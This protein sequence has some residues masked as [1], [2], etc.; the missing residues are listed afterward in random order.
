[1]KG[2]RARIGVA[3]LAVLA[4]GGVSA[5]AQDEHDRVVLDVVSRLR[6]EGRFLEALDASEDVGDPAAAEEARLLVTWE[7]G[8]LGGALHHGLV[9]LEAQPDH[10]SLL[11]H[12]TR[13]ALDLAAAELAPR[14]HARL[15]RAV[16]GATG[17]DPSTREAWTLEI[18]RLAGPVAELATSAEARSAALARARAVVLVGV[19]LLAAL[20]AL[21][22]RREAS[23]SD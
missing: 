20:W 11:W 5:A 2:P 22:S 15:E 23:T 8:D 18:E 14:L 13:L 9:G 4:V 6:G 21:L 1:M 17:L 10:L 12:T 19:S 7:A 16:D 3:A